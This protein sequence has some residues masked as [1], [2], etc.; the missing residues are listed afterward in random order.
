MTT[1]MT[2]IATAVTTSIV[3]RCQL[4][5]FTCRRRGQHSMRIVGPD[6]TALTSEDHVPAASFCLARARSARSHRSRIVTDIGPAAGAAAGVADS[7]GEMRMGRSMRGR[8][9][10]LDGRRKSDELQRPRAPSQ[11]RRLLCALLDILRDLLD[12]D[13]LDAEHALRDIHREAGAESCGCE[14]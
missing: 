1:M 5:A 4:V 7:V 10:G 12:V 14:R 6:C 9:G 3:M 8:N 11:P 13:A 2:D